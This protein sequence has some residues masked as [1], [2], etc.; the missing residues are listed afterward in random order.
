MG[1]TARHALA[2]RW[3]EGVFVWESRHGRSTA[4]PDGHTADGAVAPRALRGRAQAV[5]RLQE[6][7]ECF[8]LIADYQVSDYVDD[9]DHVRRSVWEV[10]LD[11]LRSGSTRERALRDRVAGAAACGADDAAVV[12]PAHGSAAE[13]P[14]AEERDGRAGA[15]EEERARRVLHLSA[16]A[17]REHPAAARASRAGRRRP[18][19]AHR[20]D[21]RCGR[22]IQSR[23]GRRGVPAAEAAAGRGDAARRAAG[24][25]EDE[26]VGEQRAST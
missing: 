24:R 9:I 16:D 1:G 5:G 26:Q 3:G 15:D 17:D 6:E 20:A 25:R 18:A 8:F 4:D 23:D 19:S 7:Y 10:A 2:P 12:V 21:A 22:A 14:D 11:W 13:E